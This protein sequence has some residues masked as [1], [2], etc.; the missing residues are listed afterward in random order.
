[1]KFVILSTILMCLLSYERYY[2]NMILVGQPVLQCMN[3]K[4]ETNSLMED[5][6]QTTFWL[7]TLH[8]RSFRIS[9][10]WFQTLGCIPIILK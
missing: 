7:L 1:M 9:V 6:C 4:F 5:D 2:K 8:L 3:I 10:P